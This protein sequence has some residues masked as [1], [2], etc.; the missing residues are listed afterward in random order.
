MG[1]R[2]RKKS[3]SCAEFSTIRYP[4]YTYFSE[5]R[6]P[7]T[8]ISQ[9]KLKTMLRH[10]RNLSAHMLNVLESARR[11]QM[12]GMSDLEVVILDAAMLPS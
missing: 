12:V 11:R 8:Q 3:L 6:E 9:P 1:R 10:P 7:A 4:E 2:Y 5:R